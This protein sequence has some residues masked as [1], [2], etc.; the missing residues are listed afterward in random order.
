MRSLGLLIFRLL[1]CSLA[2]TGICASAQTPTSPSGLELPRCIADAILHVTASPAAIAPGQSSVVSWSVTLP[3]GCAP[4][5]VRLNA[6]TVLDSGSK[7]VTPLQTTKY[8]LTIRQTLSQKSASVQILLNY[9]DRVVIDSS[10]PNPA[11]VLIGA[12]QSNPVTIELCLDDLDLTGQSLL[13][14]ND[15][16]LVA[17]AACARGPRNRGPRI[18]VRD[19][20]D[21]DR[22]LF[23]VRGDRVKISGFRLEGPTNG[24]G[25][26]NILERAI[27]ISPWECV[28]VNSPECQGKCSTDEQCC[29]PTPIEKIEISN[30][31]IYYWSGAAIQVDDNTVQ[32]QRGRL[33]NSREGA[34]HIYD[35]YFHANQHGDG[36]GYGVAV[37][38][39][40]Y[41]LI[42]RNV[43][44]E[45]RH[46]IEGGSSD[47]KM[48]FSGYTARDNLILPGGGKHVSENG[49]LRFAS[50]L[51]AALAFRLFTGKRIDR[52]QTHQIDMHG[53]K[54]FRPGGGFFTPLA[55]L[56]LKNVKYSGCCGIAGETIIIERNT[57]L[58]ISGKAIKIRGNPGDKAV[59]DGNVFTHLSR[60]DAIEQNGDPKWYQGIHGNITKPIDV[61]PNNV[62]KVLPLSATG[63]C[64]F[65]GD[66]IQ[67]TFAAT[68]V[69]WWAW[70]P[71]TQQWRYLNTMP[72]PFSQVRLGDFDHDGKCD[73]GMGP[74]NPNSSPNR[75]SKGGI[76]SWIPLG[77]GN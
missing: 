61:R 59:V 73:V 6:E 32:S 27:R 13:I 39:G 60:G 31:E 11:Q 26:G 41:A 37:D 49:F 52:W 38:S 65:V 50:W 33:F 58:Y 40:A 9:P 67:D 44:D 42:E 54:S 75:Y 17:G 4:V 8:T 10:T 2:S 43:F 21:G 3:T 64:D 23:S 63:R 77:V 57:I 36:Y 76:T 30:M 28:C 46:A 72:E 45:N 47:G 19:R 12:L 25:T 48:D 20:R 35:N 7:T 70:S 24:I 51:P 34:V 68:G 53:N 62:F 71:K 55:P 69:T 14:D 1:I 74:P 29:K 15:T 66:G 16:S 22:P 18:F 5:N 56:I